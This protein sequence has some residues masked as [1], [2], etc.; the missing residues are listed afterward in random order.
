MALLAL[1]ISFT[2]DRVFKIESMVSGFMLE[3]VPTVPAV[4]KSY[5]LAADL[6]AFPT[7]DWVH[8]AERGGELV[9]VAAV[10]MEAWNRRAV[11]HHLYVAPEAR[12][13]GVGHALVNAAIAAAQ[14]WGARCLWAETQT[15]NYGAVQF[16]RSAGF[17]WCGLDTSLYDRNALGSDEVALFF[18]RVIP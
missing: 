18:S 13:L 12:R 17:A 6:D 9:G 4:R 16:Y 14:P 3:E 2:T 10:K 8:I 11:L 15:V 5:S 7:H 1:D